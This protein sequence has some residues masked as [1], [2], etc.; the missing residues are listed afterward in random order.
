MHSFH[1]FFD[2]KYF[3]ISPELEVKFWAY[4]DYLRFGEEGPPQLIPPSL[5]KSQA[6][7]LAIHLPHAQSASEDPEGDDDNVNVGMAEVQATESGEQDEA[8]NTLVWATIG[9]SRVSNSNDSVFSK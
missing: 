6:C 7:R 2:S 9:L 4:N 5:V 1:F 8:G 3:V